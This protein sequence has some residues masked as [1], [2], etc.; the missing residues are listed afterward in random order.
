[1]EKILITRPC[2]DPNVS[3]L[4]SWS[5]EILNFA[6][7]NILFSDFKKEK[8][9]RE[10]V[11]KF[12]VKQNPKFIMFN[13]HGSPTTIAGHK[14][15]TL[16]ES[17]DNEHLLKS[18]ITYAVAC[19]AA[20]DLGKKVVEKGGLAFIGYE[21]PFGFAHEPSRECAPGKDKFAE[22]FKAISNEIVFSI[23]KG[24]TVKES[25]NKSQQLCLRLI[26]KYSASDADKEHKTIRFWLFWDKYFQQFYGDGEAR[27]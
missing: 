16:I 12:L 7:G 9:N 24:H 21:G 25:F 5:E 13:G 2:H 20:V 19:N 14:D 27:F 3:Y 6:R 1:M 8:A 15:E 18:A 26:K 22:P 23:L 10:E 17:N 11:S 4:Y